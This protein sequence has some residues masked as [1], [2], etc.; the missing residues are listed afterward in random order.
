VALARVWVLRKLANR[1]VDFGAIG[2]C[3]SCLVFFKNDTNTRSHVFYRWMNELPV[4]LLL[5]IVILVVT[6]PF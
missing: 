2:R 5:A 3:A 6:K 1:K 4:L